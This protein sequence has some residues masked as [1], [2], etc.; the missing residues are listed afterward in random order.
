[1]DRTNSKFDVL[2]TPVTL[3]LKYLVQL[4]GSYGAGIL[5]VSEAELED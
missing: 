5:T 4:V 2:H 1:M 3:L